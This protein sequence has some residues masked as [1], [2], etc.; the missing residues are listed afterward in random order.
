M[1]MN[2][3]FAPFS[4][5]GIVTVHERTAAGLAGAGY[6]L[7]ET[8]SFKLN[9]TQ[10]R[11]EMKTSRDASRG[12]AYQLSGQ[13]GGSL[14]IKVATLTD[15]MLSLLT[16]GVWTDSAAGAA[17]VG[18]VAPTVEVGQVIALPSGNVSGVVVK[19]STGT[20][21][22]LAPGKNYTLDAFAGTI[23]ITGLTTDGPFVQPLKVDYTPGEIR[24]MGSLKAVNKDWWVK[25]AGT[26]AYNGERMLL[27]TFRVNFAADG[28]STWIQEGYGEWVLKGSIIRD[29]LKAETAPGGQYYAIRRP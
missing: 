20:P 23:T 7:G 29:S 2:H 27:D 13:A 11:A 6:D 3:N 14:E 21:K 16:Q 12:V 18:W 5:V 15:S 19:D 25:L 22:T 17:V 1:P 9:A 26:N 28:D 4:G 24:T 8:P 10:Q